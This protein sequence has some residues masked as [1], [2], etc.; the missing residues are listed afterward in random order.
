MRL[1]EKITFLIHSLILVLLFSACKS[2]NIEYS[3]KVNR[4]INY[5]GIYVSR[6]TLPPLNKNFKSEITVRLM[7]FNKDQ[8]VQMS[9]TYVYYQGDSD[10]LTNSTLLKWLHDFTSYNFAIKS[11]TKH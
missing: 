2:K 3:K 11:K 10:N 7:K 5:N 6:D 9:N 1:K 8:S 4:L